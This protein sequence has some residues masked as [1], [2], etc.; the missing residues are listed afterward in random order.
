M[1]G[2]VIWTAFSATWTATSAAIWNW[3]PTATS[4]TAPT[5]VTATAT[6]PIPP[7]LWTCPLPVVDLLAVPPQ[8]WAYNFLSQSLQLQL[9]MEWQN[10]PQIIHQQLPNLSWQIPVDDFD[11]IAASVSFVISCDKCNQSILNEDVSNATLLCISPPYA[12]YFW[13]SCWLASTNMH[14][15]Q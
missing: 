1:L 15:N 6:T 5:T 3:A 11:V 4:A 8:K 14:Q 13:S 9:F 10:Q 2:F 12:Q 7:S